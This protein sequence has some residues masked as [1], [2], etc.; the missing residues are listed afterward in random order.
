[1]CRPDIIYPFWFKFFN[2]WNSFNVKSLIGVVNVNEMERHAMVNLAEQEK[3]CWGCRAKNVDLL[4]CAVCKVAH[5][6]SK[7]CQLADWYSHSKICQKTGVA[8]PSAIDYS[9]AY[10]TILGWN[11]Y[12]SDMLYPVIEQVISLCCILMI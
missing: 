1:M 10:T 6:C 7:Q 2:H 4:K 11:P 8:R 3:F 5:Y 12:H 9:V